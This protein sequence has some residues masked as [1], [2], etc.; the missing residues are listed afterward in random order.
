MIFFVI[1][2]RPSISSV[3]LSAHGTSSVNES[4][5]CEVGEG[6]GGAR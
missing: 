3:C 2:F 5:P 6:I 4:R 1:G